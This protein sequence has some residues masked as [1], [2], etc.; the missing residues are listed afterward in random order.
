MGILWGLKG[1]CWHVNLSALYLHLRL[2]VQYERHTHHTICFLSSTLVD[3]PTPNVTLFDRLPLHNIPS[4]RLEL[5]CAY[6]RMCTPA[7]TSRSMLAGESSQRVRLAV[8]VHPK[9]RGDGCHDATEES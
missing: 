8:D 5:E 1:T 2:L 7:Y 4:S 9:S 3:H 6:Y